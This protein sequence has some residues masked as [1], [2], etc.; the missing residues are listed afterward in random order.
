MTTRWNSE[1]DFLQ[2]LQHR[3]AALERRLDSNTLTSLYPEIWREI[4]AAGNPVFVN[5]WVNYDSVVDSTAAFRKED[6]GVIRLKGTVKS[7]AAGTIIF[8]LPEGY[9]P[10]RRN[11]FIVLAGAAEGRVEILSGGAVVFVSGTNTL[12]QL[13]NLAFV[14]S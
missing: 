4:G 12:V 8:T 1:S 13:N 6:G 11:I 9:R 14:A 2:D 3:I 7:G 10:P 5:S